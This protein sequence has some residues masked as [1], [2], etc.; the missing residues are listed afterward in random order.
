MIASEVQP[1]QPQAAEK[2][3]LLPRSD[4]WS[5]Q[6]VFEM[7]DAT[8]S[9]FTVRRNSSERTKA[10]STDIAPQGSN[11]LVAAL[12]NN[13]SAATSSNKCNF[14]AYRPVRIQFFDST[15][16]RR[17]VQPEY[18]TEAV[19]KG[20]EGRVLV[21]ALVNQAGEIEKACAVEGDELLRPAAESATLQWRYKPGYGLA[22]RRPVTPQNPQNY[23]EVFIDFE[24]NLKL[25]KVRPR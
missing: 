9:K 5:N 1:A 25:N 8:I 7:R 10:L 24:F 2:R 14:S 18:P 23:A 21:K 19:A 15:F 22:F 3:Q 6:A 12:D 4:N 11:T 20:L 17:K 13:P 16:I